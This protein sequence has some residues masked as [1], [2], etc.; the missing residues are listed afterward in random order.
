MTLNNLTSLRDAFAGLHKSLIT[1][2]AA[3]MGF[4]G[5]PLQLLEATQRDQSFA[6]LKPMT[7]LLLEMDERA[8]SR[9]A[10]LTAKNITK[11]TKQI[12]AFIE[13]GSMNSEIN[14]ALQ[15]SPDVGLSIGAIRRAL[16]NESK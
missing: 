8:A 7:A 4:R 9:D 16:G 11:F 15:S 2:Q 13:G 14:R 12:K 3:I 1:H 5:T 6:W 10:P